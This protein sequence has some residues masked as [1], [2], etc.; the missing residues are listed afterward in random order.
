MKKIF[1]IPIV[2]IVS[3]SNLFAQPTK[4]EIEK[5]MKEAKAEIEKMKKD[6]EMKEL[7]KDM[8]DMDSMMK[9]MGRKEVEAALKNVTMASSALSAKNKKLLSVLPKKILNAN[10]FTAYLKTLSAQLTQHIKSS[11]ADSVRL[12]LKQLGNDAEK[13][14]YAA[15][16]A[17][18]KNDPEAAVLL[19]SRAATLSIDNDLSLSNCAAIFTLAGLENKAIPILQVLL[20][21]QPNSSTVL[22]NI[23]QAYSGLGEVDTAMYYFGRCIKIAPT[24]PEA[25]NTAASI[26][27]KKGQ[28][29]QAKKSCTQSLKGGLTGEAVQT[30]KKLFKDD[31]DGKDIDLKPWKV[32]PFNEHDFTFPDQCEKNADAATVKLEIEAYEKRYRALLKKYESYKIEMLGKAEQISAQVAKNPLENMELTASSTPYTRRASYAYHRIVVALMYE[33]SNVFFKRIRESKILDTEYNAK[34]KM[35]EK[36]REQD[37]LACGNDNVCMVKVHAAHCRQQDELSDQYLSRYAV[38]NRDYVKKMWRINKERF[39]A[40]S[41]YLKMGVKHTSAAFYRMEAYR[42]GSLFHD[43]LLNGHIFHAGYKLIDPYCNMSDAEMKRIDSLELKENKNCNIN[44]EVPMGVAK[45]TFNCDE[46]EFEGGEL[47]K[48]KFNKNFRSGQTTLYV[49]VGAG[50]TIPG[51]EASATQYVFVCF[52]KNNQPVDVGIQGEL[53]LDVKGVVKGDQKI[54]LKTSMNTGITLEPGPLKHLTDVLPY[55]FK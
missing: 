3:I 20:Q 45:M 22:N 24:H 8:P 17:W 34:K 52:D 13:I 48:A 44:V 2:L 18:Y 55:A 40:N 28:T 14:S 6:P 7:M 27:L 35:L 36:K 37:H 5:M 26:Y 21:R 46:F 15:M 31:Y 53:E 33:E 10:E 54:I 42:I 12:T 32:Y 4:A 16:A 39:Q 51:F 30:Y 29:E 43:P 49:G 38:I 11:S 19:A 25:N 41:V 23:A 9:I 50:G 47:I 1:L